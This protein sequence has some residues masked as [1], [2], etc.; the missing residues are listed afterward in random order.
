MGKLNYH[1]VATEASADPME[2]SGAGMALQRCPELTQGDKPLYTPS[3]KPVIE[4]K[5]APGEGCY[6]G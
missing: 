5:L 3:R 1:A 6:L 4:Y 2:S